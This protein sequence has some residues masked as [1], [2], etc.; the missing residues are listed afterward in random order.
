MNAS[1][2]PDHSR[3]HIHTWETNRWCRCIH[4]AFYVHTT[5]TTSWCNG[6]RKRNRFNNSARRMCVEYTK[7]CAKKKRNNNAR[8][9]FIVCGSSEWRYDMDDEDDMHNRFDVRCAWEYEYWRNTA[10]ILGGS[11]S[12]RK[13]GFVN[14]SKLEYV[15]NLC[16]INSGAFMIFRSIVIVQ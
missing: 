4:V 10:G 3:T 5:T 8:M 14:Q 1:L 6:A 12:W 13:I 16:R 15:Y 9:Y 7:W 11:M 2:Q